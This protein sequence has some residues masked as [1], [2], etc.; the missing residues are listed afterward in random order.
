VEGQ[1]KT[2]YAAPVLRVEGD[3]AG[4]TLHNLAGYSSDATYPSGKNILEGVLS[5]PKCYIGTPT[6]FHPTGNAGC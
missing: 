3:V 1:R 2:S 5:G 6:G 4:L